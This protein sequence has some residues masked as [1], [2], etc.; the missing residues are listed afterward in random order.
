MH[1]EAGAPAGSGRRTSLMLATDL[2]EARGGLAVA[3]AVGVWVAGEAGPKGASG[4]LLAEL[5]TQGGRGPT[6]LASTG[7]RELEDGLREAGFQ[8]VAARGRLCWL[9]LAA[10]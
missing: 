8:R 10:T 4:V 2:G 9:G 7:A 1:A 5:G 6:M 3:A